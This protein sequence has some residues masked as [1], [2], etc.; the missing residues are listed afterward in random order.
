MPE[1]SSDH[2]E[3]FQRKEQARFSLSLSTLV[4]LFSSQ[5]MS[6][7][8]NYEYGK[9]VQTRWSLITSVK[10]VYLYSTVYPVISI[11]IYISNNH[12][13]LPPKRYRHPHVPVVFNC[14]NCFT[15]LHF[16]NPHPHPLIPSPQVPKFPCPPIHTQFQLSNTLHFTLYI[17]YS[18]PT[19]QLPHTN[20]S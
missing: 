20:P 8:Y 18:S 10:D 5:D 4:P 13:P 19:T 3:N 17:L 1:I 7:P 16:H 12:I 2:L 6:Y 14:F 11:S 9:G 15:S